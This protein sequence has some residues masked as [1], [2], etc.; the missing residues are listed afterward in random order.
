MIMKNISKFLLIIVA[1]ALTLASCDAFQD[2]MEPTK[3][4]AAP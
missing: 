2:E 4:I 3:P 1:G